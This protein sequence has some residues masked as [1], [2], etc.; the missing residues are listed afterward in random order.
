MISYHM[1]DELLDLTAHTPELRRVVEILVEELRRIDENSVGGGAGLAMGELTERVDIL[2][3]SVNDIHDRMEQSDLVNRVTA[4]EE[5]L[6]LLT[7]I[8]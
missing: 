5:E 1:V 3:N 2:L 7:N 8:P 4:V 6:Q